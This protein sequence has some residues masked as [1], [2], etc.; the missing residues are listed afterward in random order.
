MKI[1]TREVRRTK[2]KVYS[3]SEF[4]YQAP[5]TVP[6]YDIQ[7]IFYRNFRSIQFQPSNLIR[8][9]LCGQWSQEFDRLLQAAGIAIIVNKYV[10]IHLVP[11]CP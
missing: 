6:I 4:C 5:K 3:S 10:K 2:L 1:Q 7:Q 8:G 9:F 11:I